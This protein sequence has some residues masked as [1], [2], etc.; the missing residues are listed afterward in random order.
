MIKEKLCY[1]SQDFVS[2]R[3][4]LSNLV[5]G[6]KKFMLPDNQEFTLSEDALIPEIYFN[7]RV[8]S[9]FYNI[10]QDEAFEN[11]GLYNSC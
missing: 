3:D 5:C 8:A 2:E 4:H 10:P 6:G 9:E 1:T 11:L 7:Q